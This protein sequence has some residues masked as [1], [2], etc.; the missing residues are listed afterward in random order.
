MTD[1]TQDNQ[2]ADIGDAAPDTTA[3]TADTTTAAV[4]T[5]AT[6]AKEVTAEAE[7]K[8]DFPDDWRQKLSKGDEKELK[9]LERMKSPVDLLTAYRA[10]EKKMSS[11]EVKASLKKDATA[12]QI[13]AWRAENGIPEK[14]EDYDLTLPDGLKIADTDK[15]VIDKVLASMHS[16]NA[17]PEA[18]KATL[19]AYYAAQQEQLDQLAA[20]D[21]EFEIAT[22][23]ELRAEWG[24]EYKG[25]I[26]SIENLLANHADDEF[27]QNL[28]DGRL[29]N[30][31][32]I[33]DDPAT[34]RFLAGLARE[35]NPLATITGGSSNNAAASIDTELATL[36]KQMADLSS[37][38]WKGPNVDKVQA[39]WREL[40]N[41]QSK[42][43]AR[44]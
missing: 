8:P 1:E 9:R 3:T 43:K 17:S 6:T 41:A 10:L 14:P 38:Y 19:G 20:I 44:G 31:S 42:Y 28:F 37:E 36:N 39:R 25:N 21:K 27:K 5:E 15:P 30:G 32:K 11:G 22:K 34:L 4:T 40:T 29:A 18:V 12:E 26:N 16:V 33:K 13:T 2:A 7:V 23:V 24:S 35:I